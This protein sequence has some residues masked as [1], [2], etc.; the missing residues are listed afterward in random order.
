MG[1][2]PLVN[3]EQLTQELKLPLKKQGRRQRRGKEGG[4]TAEGR[5]TLVHK[6]QILGQIK[7]TRMPR[8]HKRPRPDE[9][10]P[11]RATP[12]SST[13]HLTTTT[14]TQATT[15]TTTRTPARTR[16]NRTTRATYQGFKVCQNVK[17]F[18]TASSNVK[19]IK[20]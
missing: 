19:I 4:R 9:R 14:T 15:R 17:I 13:P 16:T 3:S 10:T 5:A 2:I 8:S 7:S 6:G 12:T 1:N 11:L 18:I 20:L